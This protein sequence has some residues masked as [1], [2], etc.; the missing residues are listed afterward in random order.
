VTIELIVVIGIF[1]LVFVTMTNLAF[2]RL[3]YAQ[4]LGSA[5]EAK[6]AGELLATA[7]HN[8]YANGEGFSVYLEES[9][10]NFSRLSS[11]RVEGSGVVLPFSINTSAKAISINKN[12]SRAGGGTWSASV[13]LITGKVDRRNP[14]PS[15][16]E[17]TLLN[18]GSHV[19]IYA[20]ESHIEVN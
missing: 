19:L 6:M 20:N 17:V 11:S 8:V 3:N 7:I 9:K 15:Y 1:V 14:T 2:E 13:A 18:N 10:L 12:T 5:G 4:E 16:P